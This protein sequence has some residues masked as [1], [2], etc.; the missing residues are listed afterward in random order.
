MSDARTL[1]AFC[2]ACETTWM[3]PAG[4]H[5]TLG[6]NREAWLAY[7]LDLHGGSCE[8][9]LDHEQLR[10]HAV[11]VPES[12]FREARAFVAGVASGRRLASLELDAMLAQFIERAAELRGGR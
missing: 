6:D 3:L 1:Y 5:E 10:T 12:E 9:T 11:G 2:S 4:D 7:H 8:I